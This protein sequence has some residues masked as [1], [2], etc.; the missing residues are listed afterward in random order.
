MNGSEQV[1]KIRA[2]ADQVLRDLLAGEVIT[3][4][5]ALILA[6]EIDRLRRGDFTEEEFQTLCHNFSED[7]E[8]R[9]RAGCE[10]YC[11]KLFGKEKPL[12]VR[13]AEKFQVTILKDAEE[14]CKHM[15]DDQLTPKQRFAIAVLS[16]V[17]FM[18]TH[19][20]GAGTVRFQTEPCTISVVEGKWVVT[21]ER[22]RA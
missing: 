22:P 3:R 1:K 4:P 7:D 2:V 20:L 12:D 14:A 16:G 18:S 9:F 8:K 11:A 6:Q 21:T 17:R 19:D 13:H 10:S 15:S 5:E